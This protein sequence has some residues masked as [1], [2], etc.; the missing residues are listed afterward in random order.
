M[1]GTRKLEEG[2]KAHHKDVRITREVKVTQ[3]R[4]SRWWRVRKKSAEKKI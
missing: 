4:Y 1:Q 2:T 3:E